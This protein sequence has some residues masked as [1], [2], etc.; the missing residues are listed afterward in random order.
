M[1][2]IGAIV[3]NHAYKNK[4]GEDKQMNINA[5]P[6]N[7]EKY[8]AFM[9]GNHLTFI[10][11]FQFMRSSLEKLVSNMPKESFKYTSEVFEGKE[12]DL[13]VRKGV[14]PYDYMDSFDKFNEKLPSKEEFYSLL[15]DEHIS[16]EDYEH[17]QNVWNTFSLKN[18]GDYHNLYLGSDVL[19]LADV[20]ENFRKT[21]LEYYKLDPCHYFTSPGLSWDAMLKMTNIKLELM[22]DVDMFQFIEKGLRGG[23]SYIA[24]RY[25]EANNKYMKTY[26]KKAPSKY[27]MYLD[28]NNL[29]GWAMSQYLPTGGFKWLSQKQIDKINLAKYEVDSKKGL[30]LEVDLEYPEKLHDLHNDYPLASEKLKVTKDMLSPYCKKIAEKYGISIGLVQ[31]LI[32]TLSKKEKYV[33]HYRNLQLY[34]DLGLKVTKVHRVLEFNQTPWLKQYIDFNTEKRKNAK[35]AFEK[36]FFKLMNNSVF[37][38]TMENIRKRVDVRLVTDEK[39]LLKLTSKPTYVSSKI[40]NE[41][42]VAVH[43]IKE[44]L[45]LN[46]PAYVG[47]CILDL[48]K[49]L[50][51]NF[52]YNY[53]KD[54]YGDKAKLLFTDTDSLTYEIEAKDV[55]KDFW[56]DK[57]DNS[58]YSESSTYFDKTNKKV[59][60]KFKDEAAGLPIGEFVGLRSKMYSYIK[61]DQKGGKTAKGIKKN[62]IKKDITH[63]NYKQTL[64]NNQQMYHKMKTIRSENHQLG[65][66]EINKVSLSCF[67][68]KRYISDDGITSYAYG[69]KNII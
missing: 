24:N 62:V 21:C 49:T 69:H 16:N 19:L 1:Q 57:F 9:L 39:K 5:I 15:N 38:K 2:E 33:L 41:N 37:G 55:Y 4:K 14:Y 23:I 8:M 34:L 59:I 47:M 68:D 66:Y 60:G 40:F 48:S 50:M 63:E 28:A 11:S 13:M 65:S 67:D 25:G 43:K 45:T 42:L 53:I 58:D 27:I 54:K 56:N 61:D 36:D 26:D 12:F 17:A 20:F 30:I 51:Y 18:M 31:K 22:T 32:P 46:R 44:K 35:N 6:N 7:M 64:F 29:Y 3:K 52:H 10:D